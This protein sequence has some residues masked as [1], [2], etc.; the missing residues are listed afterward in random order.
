M[1]AITKLA[2]RI[3][4]QYE[5]A[6]EKLIRLNDEAVEELVSLLGTPPQ[7]FNPETLMSRLSSGVKNIPTD[8]ARKI[9]DAL[10]SLSALRS[11]TEVTIE[12]FTDEVLRALGATGNEQF[13]LN[14]DSGRHFKERLIRLLT[15]KSFT[16]ATRALD[17]MFEHQHTLQGLRII[18]DIRSVY[19]S[20]PD[21]EPSAAII[22]HM[23]K[24]RYV[25]DQES[26]DFFVAL[27]TADLRILKEV[28]E[29]AEKKTESLKET[30]TRT[31]I[32]YVDA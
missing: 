9:L 13:K 5:V 31:G 10:F 17:L 32:P 7:T 18:S 8:D 20:P 30:L 23:L 4:K 27:D 21:A 6:F 15:G 22:V 26:R 12:E 29:R 25:E 16:V 3:P 19:T 14:D 28:V 1:A 2:I 24:I 11:E